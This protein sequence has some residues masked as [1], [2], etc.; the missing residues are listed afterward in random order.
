MI[1][2]NNFNNRE[3]VLT[4]VF[5]NGIIL[6]YVSEELRADKEVVLIAVG[7]HGYA[8]QYASK[9]L[10]EDKLFLIE[11]YRLNKNTNKYN[12]F[13]KE[14]D[15]LENGYFDDTFI[16]K[17]LDILDL[18]ENKG[19][20][21]EYLLKNNK[22]RIIYDNENIAEYIKKN[23]KIVILSLDDITPSKDDQINEDTTEEEI[24]KEY[25]NRYIGLQVI[26]IL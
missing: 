7:S 9:E 8:L 24:K 22:Y 19:K 23:N 18:V 4:A 12:N 26:F 10:R 16:E 11:C 3:V 5:N 15:K 21:C 2:N 20:L 1:N 13:I 17:N 25:E 14:F 6:R